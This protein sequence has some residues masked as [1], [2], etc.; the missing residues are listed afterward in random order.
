MLDG[1]PAF[2]LLD[3]H[4]TLLEAS[5][6]LTVTA[7][8]H[9]HQGEYALLVLQ[10]RRKTFIEKLPEIKELFRVYPSKDFNV[11]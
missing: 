9:L 2:E 11:L 3:G 5:H 8:H 4:L 7:E 6:A 1:K 10:H